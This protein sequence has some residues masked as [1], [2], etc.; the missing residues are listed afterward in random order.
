MFFPFEP[1]TRYTP[2]VVGWELALLVVALEAVVEVLGVV[3]VE[4]GFAL[5]VAGVAEDAMG[6]GDWFVWWRVSPTPSPAAI[7]TMAQMRKPRIQKRFLDKRDLRA[8]ESLLMTSFPAEASVS[9]GEN[10]S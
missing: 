7:A 2:S 1:L 5:I 4:T 8:A 6:A 3:D 9:I 10:F